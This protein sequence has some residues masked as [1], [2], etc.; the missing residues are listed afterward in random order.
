MSL[1]RVQKETIPES[2][3][4]TNIEACDICGGD[5]TNLVNCHECGKDLCRHHIIDISGMRNY[6]V[7]E[8]TY[9]KELSGTCYCKTCLLKLIKKTFPD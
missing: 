3:R 8:F 6:K 5:A 1:V 4:E 2:V 9:D 7:R